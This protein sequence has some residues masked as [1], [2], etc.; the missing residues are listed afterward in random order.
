MHS[1]YKAGSLKV[2]MGGLGDLLIV[3][4]YES[5][6]CVFDDPCSLGGDYF[7]CYVFQETSERFVPW[8]QHYNLKLFR[9]RKL[10]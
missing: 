7:F 5:W 8:D 3:N 10:D 9:P 1:Q 2:R 6:I 4:E